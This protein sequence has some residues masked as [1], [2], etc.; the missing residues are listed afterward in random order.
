MFHCNERS[1]EIARLFLEAVEE[2]VLLDADTRSAW[3]NVLAHLSAVAA[4]ALDTSVS[5]VEDSVFSSNERALLRD[6]WAL[7]RVNSNVAPKAFVK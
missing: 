4:G 3:K 5:R 6:M 1:Q 7:V 2:E